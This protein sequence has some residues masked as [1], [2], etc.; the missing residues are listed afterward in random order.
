VDSPPTSERVVLRREPVEFDESPHLGQSG[1]GPDEPRGARI[2]HSFTDGGAAA[3]TAIRSRMRNTPTM[4]VQPTTVLVAEDDY[5][6][7]T[8]I[9]QTLRADGYTV[10]GAADGCEAP[11]QLAR[12]EY[13]FPPDIVV[14]DVWMPHLCGLGVLEALHEAHVVVPVIMMT[15]KGNASVCADAKRLGAVGVLH[16][17]FDADDSRTVLLNAEEVLSAVHAH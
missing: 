10:V 8:I 3:I 14:L 13:P 5:D 6:L 12:V 1:R 9:A 15:A 16:K 7:R 17:P 11:D 2:V 4:P